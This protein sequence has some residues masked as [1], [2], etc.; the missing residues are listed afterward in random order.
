MIWGKV[1]GHISE[2]VMNVMDMHDLGT[3]P[4]NTKY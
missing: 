3:H 2:Q 1:S 4:S